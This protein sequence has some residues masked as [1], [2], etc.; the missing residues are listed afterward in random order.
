MPKGEKLEGFV[1]SNNIPTEGGDRLRDC[2]VTF[3]PAENPNPSMS[4]PATL[5][6]GEGKLYTEEELKAIMDELLDQVPDHIKPWIK[7]IA[8]KH[9]IT[10]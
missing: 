9:G 5:Y 6:M 3:F 8:T 4:I 1:Y 7:D 2:T 10:P